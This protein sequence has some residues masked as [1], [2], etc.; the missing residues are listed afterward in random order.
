MQA[1]SLLHK[2]GLCRPCAANEL[3]VVGVLNEF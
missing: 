2:P 1:A 3:G